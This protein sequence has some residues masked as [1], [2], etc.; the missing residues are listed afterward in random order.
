MRDIGVPGWALALRRC[1]GDCNKFLPEAAFG[2][3]FVKRTSE[4]KP[5]KT[6]EGCRVKQ[7]ARYPTYRDD[8]LAKAST[9]EFKEARNKRLNADETEKAKRSAYQKLPHVK[10]AT[11]ARTSTDEHKRK[12]K[13]ARQMPE[14][15]AKRTRYLQDPAIKDRENARPSRKAATARRHDKVRADP[16]L[17][18]QERLRNS[19]V[20]RL[21][22]DAPHNSVK[23]AT[24][25][26]FVSND[27]IMEH[28]ERE[29]KRYPG[30]T[31]TNHGSMWSIGH[32]IAVVWFD[33]NN[34][35]DIR[36]CNSK[37]N[38]TCDYVPGAAPAG[39][40]SNQQKWIHLPCD[41]ELSTLQSVFPASWCGKPP[42]PEVVAAKMLAVNGGKA[43]KRMC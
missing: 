40:K 33:S 15:K 32:K 39:Y 12:C 21:K 30:M 38:L 42:T 24:H 14:N 13:E 4:S 34:L 27:V 11:V 2:F 23:L 5:Y 31:L 18:L 28:F 22:N 19:M 17:L 43:K 29:C 9:T 25:T 41:E 37:L 6:C 20:R 35:D 16:G 8:I 36:K 7:N 3:R 26:E 10:A 1:A